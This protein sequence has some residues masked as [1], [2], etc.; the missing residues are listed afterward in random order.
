[1]LGTA[2]NTHKPF[3]GNLK[4]PGG[5]TEPPKGEPNALVR[6]LRNEIACNSSGSSRNPPMHMRNAR[7]GIRHLRR[8]GTNAWFFV[9][10]RIDQ[11]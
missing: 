10:V 6:T 11:Y 7:T 2:C 3:R 4:Q 8:A 1:M 5:P 9:Q